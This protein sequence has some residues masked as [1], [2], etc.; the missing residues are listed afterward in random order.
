MCG[1]NIQHRQEEGDGHKSLSLYSPPQSQTQK[2][3]RLNNE[4][5]VRES[6]A[7]FKN[8]LEG[9]GRVEGRDREGLCVEGNWT[10]IK[11]RR[12][13]PRKGLCIGE[14]LEV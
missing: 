1:R 13:I 7:V 14:I 6:A 3:Q 2:Q 10:L 11:P 9:E 12:G 8:Q 4:E 5:N